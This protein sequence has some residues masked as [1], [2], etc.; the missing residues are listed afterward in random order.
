[1]DK[2]I[3]E[4]RDIGEQIAKAA[5]T[6]H[7]RAIKRDE[8]LQITFRANGAYD[9]LV[10]SY[11]KDIMTSRTYLDGEPWDHEVK[12]S[13]LYRIRTEGINDEETVLQNQ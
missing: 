4:L 5:Q 8:Y 6:E 1:M 9:I 3:E 12:I 7:P 11:T 10:A 13:D 2:H